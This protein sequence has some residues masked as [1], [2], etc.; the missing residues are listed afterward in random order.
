MFTEKHTGI[1]ILTAYPGIS[2]VFFFRGYIQGD[3]TFWM[4]IVLVPLLLQCFGVGQKSW[5][6]A[7][8]VALIAGIC[9]FRP[10]LSWRFLLLVTTLLF[11]V[12]SLIGRLNTQVFV[13][14][15]IIS[16][17]FKYFSEVFTF[18]IRLQLSSWAGSILK[19]AGLPVTIEGNSILLNGSEFSV[20]P[21]CMGLQ[22]TG[23]TLLAVIFLI[24]HF[25][26]QDQKSLPLPHQAVLMFLAFTLNIF[27]NL[28]R[29]IM[30]VVLRIAPDNALH[31]VIGV[32]CL[33]V[34]VVAPLIFIVRRTHSR[35]S[36]MIVPR[37][38]AA[39]NF[40]LLIPGHLILLAT[41]AFFCFQ[42]PITNIGS[43]KGQE[44]TTREGYVVE[45]FKSGVTLF[46]NGNALVY[47]KPIPAFYSSEH[48][49]VTCW[50][51]SGYHLS[52]ILKKR[53]AGTVVYIGTLR[54]GD[55]ELHTAWWLSDGHHATISQLDWRWKSL[56]ET[57]HFQLINVTAQDP[58]RLDM[59]VKRWLPAF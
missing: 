8:V 35:F 18:P 51:G 17:I 43:P 32:A 29:I 41:C 19:M 15:L 27:G 45:Q 20:D 34:Y 53:L 37:E 4:G 10:E 2:T 25:H 12:E 21:A 9:C 7:P 36:K 3:A 5:R 30:L 48:S 1:A 16:P 47:I 28:A 46:R 44:V 26:K 56:T 14:M 13:V 42:K 58:V 55:D 59:E 52:R 23:F 24:A 57:S 39:G 50:T 11:A 49:P 33:M 54:K 31:D 6:L 40:R 22:M 38:T